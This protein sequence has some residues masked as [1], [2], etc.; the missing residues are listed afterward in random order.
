MMSEISSIGSGC[1]VMIDKVVWFSVFHRKN[2]GLSDG[3][4]LSESLM[5]Y[6]EIYPRENEVPVSKNRKR[7]TYFH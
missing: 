2:S 3:T 4:N 7:C 6:H 1:K 5:R